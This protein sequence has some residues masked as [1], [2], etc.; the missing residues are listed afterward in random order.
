MTV[1]EVCTRDVVSVR[2]DDTVVAVS[3]I[4][5]DRH[6]GDVVVVEGEGAHKRPVGI[7]TDRDLRSRVVAHGLDPSAP[8]STVMT[9]DPIATRPDAMALEVLLELVR[10]NIHHLPL[11]EDGS[12]VGVVSAND[13][14]RFATAVEGARG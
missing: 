5:R 8:V 3:R 11:V 9:P 1:G 4:M 2:R 7:L 14:L 10:N 12:V 13:L 6:V